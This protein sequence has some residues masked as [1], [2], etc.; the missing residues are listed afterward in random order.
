[1]LGVSLP[2]LS[3]SA[4]AGIASSVGAYA[5]IRKVSITFSF[6]TIILYYNILN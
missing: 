6:D 3:V 1:M 2:A 5:R 4:A